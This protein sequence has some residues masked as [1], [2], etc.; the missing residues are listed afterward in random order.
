[1]G[2]AVAGI[3]LFKEPATMPRLACMALIVA[4]ILGL[5]LTVR[6]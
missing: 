4:G 2:T 5:K 1:V 3:L 6:G